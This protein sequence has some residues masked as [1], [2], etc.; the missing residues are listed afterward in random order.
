MF[1]TVLVSRSLF[2]VCS[3]PHTDLDDQFRPTRIPDYLNGLSTMILRDL[4]T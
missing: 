2:G 4:V 3:S 1:K